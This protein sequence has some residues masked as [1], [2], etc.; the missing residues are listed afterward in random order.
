MY[1]VT[2]AP[3]IVSFGFAPIV[4]AGRAMIPAHSYVNALCVNSP[5]LYDVMKAMPYKWAPAWEDILSGEWQVWQARAFVDMSRVVES[6]AFMTF[7]GAICITEPGRLH[8]QLHA[9]PPDVSPGYASAREAAIARLPSS[10]HLPS[11]ALILSLYL[12]RE[13][14]VRSILLRRRLLLMTDVDPRHGMQRPPDDPGFLWRPV[15]REAP[16]SVGWFGQS[17]N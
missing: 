3:V 12:Y 14:P 4:R 16:I 10:A 5:T 9:A 15:F 6:L 13:E 7:P 8:G 2:M 1:S 11:E 17:R